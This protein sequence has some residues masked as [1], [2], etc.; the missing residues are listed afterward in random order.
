MILVVGAAGI[1][2][3][4]ITPLPMADIAATYGVALTPMAT[5][6]QRMFGTVQA[7]SKEA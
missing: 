1:P 7:D 2:G 5:V 4:T 6:L 3:G